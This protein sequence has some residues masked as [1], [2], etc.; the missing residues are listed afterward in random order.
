MSPHL[1]S[2]WQQTT[3]CVSGCVHTDSHQRFERRVSSSSAQIPLE[4]ME[5]TRCL[6]GGENVGVNV[7]WMGIVVLSA[8]DTQAQHKQNVRLPLAFIKLLNGNITLNVW[9]NDY[10]LLL[11]R[12][13]GV[14]KSCGE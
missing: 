7:E 1:R 12:V 14:Q 5:N 10:K 2:V 4:H 6:N 13:S 9:L 11:A 3:R 8:T